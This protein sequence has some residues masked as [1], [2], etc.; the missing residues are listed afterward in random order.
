MLLSRGG[1]LQGGFGRF[2]EIVEDLRHGDDNAQ[3]IFGTRERRAKFF[4]NTGGQVFGADLHPARRQLLGDEVEGKRDAD[5]F[6]DIVRNKTQLRRINI[7]QHGTQA[8]F[9]HRA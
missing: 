1:G 9:N 8:Q 6:R 4:G 2:R 3:A 5:R 7:A